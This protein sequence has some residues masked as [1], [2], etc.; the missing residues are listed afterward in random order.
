VYPVPG[1]RLR[2]RL[3][4]GAAQ[5]QAGFQKLTDLEERNIMNLKRSLNRYLLA[6]LLLLLSPAL[7]LGQ[8]EKG[9]IVGA[10]TDS[11]GAV[12]PGA[13]V[14]VTD[15]GTNTSQTFT[16]N[17]EGLYE[18]PFLTPGKYKV[19][20]T[21]RGFSTSVVG[22][23]VVSVGQRER[24][25][26]ALQ[27]GDVATQ[28]Q[29]VDTAPLLQTESATIGQVIDNKT[30][31][32]LPSGD[33][34]IY[35][36]MLLNSNVT[37]PAGGNGPA[38]RVETGGTFSI[39]GT[40]PSS[41]TFKIDGLSNTDPTFGTPTI[42]PSLDS[43]QEFQ[44]QNN[45][46]SAEY[47]GIGQVN[48]ATKAGT[49]KFHGSFFEFVRNDAL[50]P[51]NPINPPDS[52]GKPGKS[53][54]RFNQFGGAIGGP[55]FLPRFGEGGPSVSSGSTFFF[56]SYEGRRQNS[57]GP[58]VAHVPTAAE[59]NGDFSASLGACLTS[60]GAPIPLLNPNGTPSG[61][62]VRS[63][64]IFDPATTV[65]NPL[66]DSSRPAS[67]LNP[68]FIRQPFPNN[69]IP[70]ERLSPVAQALIGAQLPLPNLGAVETNF[71]GVAGGA[72]ENNQ[73]SIRID[74]SIS[75][76]DKIYGRLTLQ[77]NA[78][79]TVPL[80]AYQAKNVQGKGRVFNSTWTHVFGPTF[81]NEFRLGYVRGI[82]GDTLQATIDP[83]QF[84]IRNTLIPTLPRLA[85]FD[86]NYGGF[87]A[88]ITQ[89]IQNT[90]QLAD[91]ASL[92][93]GR[94]AFKFGLQ[95]DY[96]RFRN[97]DLGGE[98]GTATFNGTYTSAATGVPANRA[99]GVADFLL[100]LANSNSLSVN[101][102]ANVRNMPWS[103]YVQDDW[104]LKPRVTLNLGLRYELHQPY[105]EQLLGGSR[106][107]PSGGGRLVVAD[108]EVARIANSPLVVCCTGPRVVPTDKN[109]FAPRVGVAIQPFKGDNTVLRMGYGIY[110]S[111]ST[112]FF[113]WQQYQPLIGA[114]FIPQTGDFRNPGATLNDLFP[115]RAFST[116]IGIAPTFGPV[117]PAVLNNQPFIGFS[118]LGSNRTPYSQQ[119]SIGIQREV[120]RNMVLEVDYTGSNSKNLP[121]QWIFNQPTA[122][123]VAP[124]FSSTD[125]Q[126]NPYLR[127]PFPNV[128][129]SSFVVTN[130]LQSNYN[131]MTVK[132]DKRFSQG[133]SLLSTYTWSKSIDQ[134]SEVF[135][136]GN[137]F[138]IISDNRNINRDKG[139]STFDVPH[140]WVTSGI[141]E[142]PFGK[143]RRF[144][145]GGGLTDKLVG[146]WQFSGIFTL[147]SGFP[148]TPLIRN[149]RTNTSYALVTERGDLIG[150]PYFSGDQWDQMVRQWVAGNGRLYLINPASIAGTPQSGTDYA[151]GTFGN[152]PRNFFR[153][154]YGR[155]LD[156]SVAKVTRLGEVTRLELRADILGVTNERLH[157]LDL[158]QFVAANNL[159]TN[160]LVGSISEYRFFF[161][162][163][164]IQLGLRFVF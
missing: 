98:N 17:G 61:S 74:H 112:T 63:G 107:D 142:L 150:D 97:G 27:P 101:R 154:P 149:R 157:R 113:T 162:P 33:R 89:T 58:S 39:S 35:S 66:F 116:T 47:E 109:D 155:N 1:G 122:S 46:Y 62:C 36:F 148:F 78:R 70:R 137:T 8:T 10:V 110:Y 96:N 146:G 53:K 83:T 130:I 3:R 13:T 163:R 139:V 100:G 42:T 117:R 65:A 51:R 37:Q 102:L 158:A 60:G 76:R 91:N 159:L 119:W 64:Q 152:I 9:A 118:T 99:N 54:L 15:L 68:Q 111:D 19:S 4:A 126:A 82:Y 40:R 144:W 52:S 31:T 26:V 134:G 160:S 5:E 44:V 90:Y 79:I 93:R 21:A 103:V 69:Q 22:E 20:V 18:A 77:N 87:S 121:T 153:A 88:S 106:F 86:L 57:L 123:P 131:A 156:L 125:P 128:S 120:M 49:D 114:S 161:N 104:K 6:G 92:I 105:R 38:F 94:H 129:P 16:T 145:S 81:V 2:G 140:R 32:E 151:A 45:A 73:Y 147:E 136:V 56:F 133:F 24:V 59:R 132:L 48:V 164:T 141:V 75:E 67:A 115:D 95:G 29:V 11:S 84:G 7:L 34:N 72:T 14:T 12:V 30:I 41:V 138:N 135:Q 124:N 127:R 80:L 143:G 23:A 108:P 55:V 43:V 28:I 71:Q 50:Q 85:I 25:D